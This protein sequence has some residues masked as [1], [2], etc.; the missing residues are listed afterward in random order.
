MGGLGVGVGE[1]PG[2][3]GLQLVRGLRPLRDELQ[4]L[5]VVDALAKLRLWHTA[6]LG[7][8][9]TFRKPVSH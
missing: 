7:G 2:A 4:Q 6:A 1:L 3:E 9:S 5:W 8:P